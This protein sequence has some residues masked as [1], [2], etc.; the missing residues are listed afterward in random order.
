MY[1]CVCVYKILT[2]QVFI[3][4]ENFFGLSYDFLIQNYVNKLYHT[5][6]YVQGVTTLS[7]QTSFEKTH[8]NKVPHSGSFE[9]CLF[10]G[11]HSLSKPSYL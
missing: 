10:L 7:K 8:K 9:T 2:K 11:T 6:Q 4:S 1:V 5:R 3:F